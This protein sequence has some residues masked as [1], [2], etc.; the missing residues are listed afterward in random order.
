[1]QLCQVHN[2]SGVPEC[3]RAIFFTPSFLSEEKK[4]VP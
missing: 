4:W 1:M 3:L 2:L